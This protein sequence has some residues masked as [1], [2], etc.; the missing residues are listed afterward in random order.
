MGWRVQLKTNGAKIHHKKRKAHRLVRQAILF[1]AR[2]QHG[3]TQGKYNQ[4]IDSFALL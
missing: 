1:A 3:I 2:V 4:R